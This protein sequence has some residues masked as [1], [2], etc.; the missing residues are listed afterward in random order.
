MV[1][2][3]NSRFVA[4]TLNVK[5]FITPDGLYTRACLNQGNYNGVFASQTDM[6]EIVGELI[7]LGFRQERRGS[8]CFTLTVSIQLGK[9]SL[10]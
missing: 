1:A 4:E 8:N 3:D 2:A 5:S 7:G 10:C 9:L 6:S